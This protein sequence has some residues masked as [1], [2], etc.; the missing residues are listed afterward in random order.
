VNVAA[1]S[2]LNAPRLLII[3]YLEQRALWADSRLRNFVTRQPRGILGL[4][5]ISCRFSVHGDIR[6][7]FDSVPPQSTL[8]EINDTDDIDDEE[9]VDVAAGPD[10]P[11]LSRTKSRRDSMAPF[12][13]LKE[14]LR[15]LPHGAA[16]SD[17]SSASDTGTRL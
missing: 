8:D 10:G 1:V 11:M 9:Q 15:D 5:D 3:R 2:V 14:R 4:R 12:G 7:L 16:Y 13:G 6:A 17:N